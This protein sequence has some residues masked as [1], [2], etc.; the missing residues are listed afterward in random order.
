MANSLRVHINVPRRQYM[1]KTLA[2]VLF[3]FSLIAC[4]STKH[5]QIVESENKGNFRERF[6]PQDS[7]ADGKFYLFADGKLSRMA[8]A[9]DFFV[10]K[11]IR[12][13]KQNLSAYSVYSYTHKEL[14]KMDIVT[15][16]SMIVD[17]TDDDNREIFEQSGVDLF[18]QKGINSL[19]LNLVAV[20]ETNMIYSVSIPLAEVNARVY[21]LDFFAVTKI[22]DNNSPNKEIYL[23]YYIMT[24]DRKE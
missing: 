10:V 12:T 16:Q 7:I 23:K 4:S 5:W 2:I 17:L 9:G 18:K 11:S 13:D 8:P 15:P 1:K 22:C 19:E 14:I 3:A 24:G 20:D 21:N 6:L